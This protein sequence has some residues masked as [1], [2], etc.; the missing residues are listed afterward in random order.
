MSIGPFEFKYISNTNWGT[1]EDTLILTITS[2]ENTPEQFII[3]YEEDCF[4]KTYHIT[5]DWKISDPITFKEF[6]DNE[7]LGPGNNLKDYMGGSFTIYY[8]LLRE[9]MRQY[10]K[11]C[12]QFHVGNVL[13][14]DLV[15]LV[16]I[17]VGDKY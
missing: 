5:M 10:E 9:K 11:K 4:S 16:I 14:M 6:N 3:V 2:K 15:S 13:L 1:P 8:P 17:Y 12:I 7:L